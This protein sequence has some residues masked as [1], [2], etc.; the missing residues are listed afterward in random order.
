MSLRGY[1]RETFFEAIETLYKLLVK[2]VGHR[3]IPLVETLCRRQAQ[4]LAE[5]IQEFWHRWSS[6]RSLVNI[7]D[8]MWHKKYPRKRINLSIP[9][10]V[11]RMSW[12]LSFGPCHNMPHFPPV[13]TCDPCL[14][15]L[16]PWER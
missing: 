12:I 1:R 4:M 2:I 11:L 10:F 15:L 8:S 16:K 14:S 7:V 5:Q 13:L 6:P 9:I 3:R